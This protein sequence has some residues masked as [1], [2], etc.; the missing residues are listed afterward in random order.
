MKFRKQNRLSAV[1]ALCMTV[2]NLLCFL[3][4]FPAGE[5]PNALHSLRNGLLLTANAFLHFLTCKTGRIHLLFACTQNRDYFFIAVLLCLISFAIC[6][7]AARKT[8]VPAL[9]LSVGTAIGYGF[10]LF[11]SDAGFVLCWIGFLLLMTQRVQAGSE[12]KGFLLRAVCIALCVLVL[13]GVLPAQSISQEKLHTTIQTKLHRLRYEQDDPLP[14]G[15]ILRDTAPNKTKDDA[16][17]VQAEQDGEMYLRGFIGERFDGVHW[18][19]MPNEALAEYADVF[20]WLHQYGFSS[21]VQPMLALRQ[22]GKSALQTLH[23]EHISACRKYAFVPFAGSAPELFDSA[24]LHDG[25]YLAKGAAVTAQVPVFDKTALFNAQRTIAAQTDTEYLEC[26]RAYAKFVRETM[27]DVPQTVQK[28]FSR[29]I[30]TQ[31]D[32]ALA[33]KICFVLDWLSAY[34]ETPSPQ[35]FSGKNAVVW[36]L[37]QSKSGNDAMFATAGALM[38][39]YLGIPARYAEGYCM[40]A[41]AGETTVQKADAHVWTEY[42]LDGVG[43]V[44]LETVPGRAQSE[45]QFY[46]AYAAAADAESTLR[47][48]EVLRPQ[49]PMRP[50]KTPQRPHRFLRA[51]IVSFAAALFA[52]L[53]VLLVRRLRFRARMRRIQALPDKEKVAALFVYAQRICSA[54]G[55]QVQDDEAAA[56]YDEALFSNHTMTARHV[57]TMQA[58]AYE[59]AAKCKRADGGLRRIKHI[60]WDCIY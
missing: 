26:E 19:A 9:V 16:L 10:G 11:R 3:S 14:E 58:F 36:F 43:W 33:D 29:Q 35:L 7:F 13:F 18:T 59:A 49:S 21:A 20:Y 57:Q 39:R 6:F 51:V 25:T 8:A 46:S 55:I 2:G 4:V 1:I 30:D 56:L 27:L 22:A 54:C 60:L 42:Y 52:F 48:A 41:E 17:Q 38:L 15:D 34:T 28:V 40:T 47:R 45:K 31:S 50:G 44:P 32:A 23:I 37:E 53:I 5:Y 12:W 24:A